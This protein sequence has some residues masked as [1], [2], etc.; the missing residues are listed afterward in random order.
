MAVGAHAL[1]SLAD[2]RDRIGFADED[3][4]RDGKL[5]A[6]IDEVSAMVQ[7]AVNRTMRPR[8]A[9]DETE[10]ITVP[11]VRG[12][13]SIH[14]APFQARAVTAIS[15]GGTA[16]DDGDF[17]LAPLRARHGVYHRIELAAGVW[18]TSKFRQAVASITGEFGWANIPDDVRGWVLDLVHDRWRSR[19]AYYADAD[20]IAEVPDAQP[21]TI[22]Y[23]IRDE[24]SRL[25]LASVGSV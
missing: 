3:T 18:P 15:I 8:T 20:G 19:H 10:T 9:D 4:E 14:L 2:A 17:Q 22:P 25:T 6:V 21:L 23:R 16:V 5:E 11:Y 24:M 7:R 12:S 1:I 13:R